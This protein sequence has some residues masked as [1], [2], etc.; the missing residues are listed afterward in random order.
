MNR[1]IPL[2]AVGLVGMLSAHAHDDPYADHEHTFAHGDPNWGPWVCDPDSATLCGWNHRHWLR[3][4]PEH[5]DDP[6]PRDRNPD[7][8]RGDDPDDDPEPE[9][10]EREPTWRS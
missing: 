1:F 2:L 8:S 3:P 10:P 5:V 7:N 6:S 4:D 9:C